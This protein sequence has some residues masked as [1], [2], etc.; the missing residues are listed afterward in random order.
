MTIKNKTKKTKKNFFG[1]VSGFL[2]NKFGNE[3]NKRVAVM[4]RIPRRE[5]VIMAVI[6]IKIELVIRIIFKKK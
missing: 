1:L 3:K 4:T 6:G 2:G 5:I